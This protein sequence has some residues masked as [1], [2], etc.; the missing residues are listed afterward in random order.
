V[1]PSGFGDRTFD[2]YVIDLSI[3]VSPLP[4]IVEVGVGT[5]GD[6]ENCTMGGKVVDFLWRLTDL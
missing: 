2:S 1:R 6:G 4:F 3:V 5:F